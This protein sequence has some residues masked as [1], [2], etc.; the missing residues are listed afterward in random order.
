VV[1][2]IKKEYGMKFNRIKILLMLCLAL[3]S[4]N[5]VESNINKENSMSIQQNWDKLIKYWKNHHGI[6]YR[7]DFNCQGATEEEFKNLKNM[8]DVVPTDYLDSLKICAT[9]KDKENNFYYFIDSSGF[10]QLYGINDIIQKVSNYPKNTYISDKGAYQFVSG[11]LKNPPMLLPK[12][13]IPIFDWNG[14]YIVA[15]DML[16][17]NKGQIIVF[18]MED[19]TLAKWTDSY[20]EWFELVVN[21]VLQYGELRVETIEKVLQMPE[22]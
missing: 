17:E 10:G 15:I 13:W 9:S 20:E 7:K 8:Y 11:N 4:V 18:C 12:Q 21:E 3:T 19:S 5:A 22:E 2:L 1:S 16:S 6:K 14:D